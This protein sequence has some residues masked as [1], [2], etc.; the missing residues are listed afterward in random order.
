MAAM[1]WATDLKLRGTWSL[2]AA[3]AKVSLDHRAR[4]RQRGALTTDNGEELVLDLP[5]AIP[6]A[7]G[8]GLKCNDGTYV[9]VRAKV[10]PCFRL[11]SDDPAV[12]LRLSWAIGRRGVPIA[13]VDGALIVPADPAVADIAGASGAAIEAIDLAFEPDTA[14]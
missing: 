3:N 10:E 12:L 11:A 8:D 5:R 2:A 9:L 6:M 1:R 7:D 14:E 13:V 4:R